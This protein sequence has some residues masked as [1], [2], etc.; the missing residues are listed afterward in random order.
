MTRDE[1]TERAPWRGAHTIAGTA[2]AV[3]GRV[4]AL[5]ALAALAALCALGAR[6]ALGAA[7]A[8]SPPTVVVSPLPGTPDA[9]PTSQISFLGA[10]ASRLRDIVVT[11]SRS[12]THA[13][14]LRY[15]ST[16]TGGSFVPSHARSRP[17]SSVTVSATVVGY[18]A[19]VHVGTSFTV[20]SPYT[21]PA[22]ARP[23]R[24]SPRPRPNVMRVSLAPGPASRRRSR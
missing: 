17:A 5:C 7:P 19:P 24:R 3:R 23:S 14:R 18:G 8:P 1:L 9:D 22:P 2:V 13:G 12:G 20:S 10:P 21:L 11:G 6:A 16:H 4:L 15:Y